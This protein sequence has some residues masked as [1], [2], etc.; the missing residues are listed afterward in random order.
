MSEPSTPYRH[1]L[2][3]SQLWNL[4]HAMDY[5]TVG[6][7][8]LRTVTSVS[9]SQGSGS[10]DAFGRARISQPFTLFDSQ[11]RYNKRNDQYVEQTVGGASTTYNINESTL[12]LNVTAAAGD[13]V[14][15]ETTRVFA[16]QPGKSLK[17]MTTFAFDEG[18]TGLTQ[19]VGY[20]ND[21]N[22]IFF[23]NIDGVNCIVKR[24]Y[25]T[26]SVVE[27]VIPQNE[28]NIDKLDI[29]SPSGVELDS[30]KSQIFFTDM[31]WLGVGSVRAGFV[32]NGNFYVCHVFNHANLFDSTYM[33][34]ACLP[35][36]YEIENTSATV[37]SSTMKQ[38]C[39]TVI[40]EGGYD[41]TGSQHSIARGITAP[42]SMTTAGT[43]YPVVSL[44]LSSDK[45]DSIAV[46]RDMSALGIVNQGRFI[47]S[48]IRGAT[49]TGGAWTSLSGSNLEY[50]I[51]A[52]GMSGGD[53]LTN[54]VTAVTNQSSQSITLD[55]NI[56][57]FQME[58]DG[59]TGAA[60]TYTLAAVG[61]TNGSSALGAITWEELF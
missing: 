39:A 61:G 25:I 59:L 58:R 41:L 52:T 46:L 22:G 20:F 21:Q 29:A 14:T 43:A 47:F 38:I 35:V 6:E 44:R 60:Y 8:V 53:V 45:L 23:A 32:I 2:P 37:A 34:T 9:S 7:P 57:G 55:G 15:R 31:E 1:N 18:Q 12:S 49:I 36:R 48:L 28:W 16:Y 33:T 42:V 30:S 19:R 51:S 54:T 5:N 40:S 27:T 11:L 26:G 24:S 10:T 56:F 13:K 17:I 50:N 3:E 4:H